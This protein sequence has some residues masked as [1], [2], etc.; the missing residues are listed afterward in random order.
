M[1]RLPESGDSGTSWRAPLPIKQQRQLEG[2][3]RGTNLRGSV[4][5]VNGLGKSRWSTHLQG[6]VWV[7][8]FLAETA[9]VLSPLLPSTWPS[10]RVEEFDRKRP[11]TP[12]RIGHKVPGCLV[13]LYTIPCLLSG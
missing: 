9:A 13:S 5:G 12:T 11:K 10:S 2:N 1:Q 3:W 8:C 7:N 6:G 4:C